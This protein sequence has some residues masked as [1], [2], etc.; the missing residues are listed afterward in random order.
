MCLE[1]VLE[2]SEA[3]EPCGV[4]SVPCGLRRAFDVFEHKDRGHETTMQFMHALDFPDIA[5]KDHGGNTR[6]HQSLSKT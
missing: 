1:Q 3:G 4:C 2:M 5:L 6:L